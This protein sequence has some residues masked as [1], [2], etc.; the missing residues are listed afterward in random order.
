MKKAI[1]LAGWVVIAL[2]ASLDW[3]RAEIPQQAPVADQPVK[4]AKVTTP[5]EFFGFNMGDDYCLANY[6]QLMAYWKKLEGES[7]RIKIVEIGRTAEDRPQLMAIVTSPAN[8]KQLEKYRTIAR[9]LAQAEGVEPTEALR[10]AAEGKAVIWI[11]GGLHATETLCAQALIESVFQF[12]HST[13]PETTR[14]LNDVIILFVHANPDGHDLVADWYMREKD[15]KKRSLNGLPRLYQKYVGHDDNRDFYANTQAETKNLNRILYR[16]WFPQIMYNHHQTGPAGTVLFCPPFR[17]PFNY[18]VDALVT[19][20]IDSVGAAMMERFLVEGKPGATVRSGAPYST[21]FNGG[22]RTTSGFHNMIGILTETIGGPTPT[23]IPLLP[24]KQLPR[25]D[26]LAPIAPQPWHF[27][28]SV[29]Y[30]LTANRG[31]LDY[32]SRNREHL[33]H[34]IWLMGKNAIDRGD[35]DSWTITPKIVE[36]ATAASRGAGARAAASQ[37]RGARGAAGGRRGGAGGAEDFQR[38]FHDPAKRDPRGYILTADQPDFSTAAKFV[39]ALLGT[40][41]QVLRA[42]APFEAAG[43]KYPAGSY[44]VKSGQAFR[45]HVLDM[46]EPQDHPNDIPY[47]GAAPTRPYDSAGYTLAYQMGFQF[48]RILDAFSGPFEQIK[49]IAVTPPRGSVTDTKGAAGFFLSCRAND[50]FKAVNR[51]LKAG[52]K[53]QRLKGPFAAAGTNHEAGEFFIPKQAGTLAL[54]ERIAAE[55]GTSFRG[56]DASPGTQAQAVNEV[57]IGLWDRYGGSMPSGWT[58]WILEQFEFPFQRVYAP[59]LDKGDL[60]K[61]FDVLVFV[62]G[63]M[64]GRG[65]RSGRG[66]NRGAGAAGGD[67]G[68]GQGPEEG[69]IPA[70]Y[71]GQRGNIT[72]ATTIPQLKKFMEAGGTVITIGS[73]TSLYRELGL[74]MANFLVE[75]GEDGEEHPLPAEKYYVPSSVLRVRVDT[76]SPLALGMNDHVDVMFSNSPTFRFTSK[77]QTETLH[78]VAWFDSKTP[79]RSG[80]AWG[81][82]YLE[83]GITI[84]DARVGQGRLILFGPEILFRGQPHGT[85]KFFFN[86]LVQSARPDTKAAPTGG[87]TGG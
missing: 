58:R 59:E 77:A 54:L 42:K 48:D 41:V 46:F 84:A 79:L 18:H 7:D 53:V 65:G 6:Q 31:I 67:P 35:R 36:A 70:E 11:D 81:E 19:N 49:E 43:K 27:R 63:A 29:E 68:A 76:A 14:I 2:T 25:A 73:S 23:N 37:V 17:D 34:N 69:N 22:L 32:A 30:S 47:P 4:A 3:V 56:S 72:A 26:Y 28:Q 1:L 71:Y 83:G 33:L 51:L 24:A 40:G 15:P 38:L 64:S 44:I 60:N 8:H 75:V 52:A 62:D 45:A 74:P 10:L 13:D 39:N 9:R 85:F 16:E 80:W 78:N 87:S 57:R 55:V 86:G 61:K 20:G 21:W 5:K 50:S 82:K 66:G 12:V